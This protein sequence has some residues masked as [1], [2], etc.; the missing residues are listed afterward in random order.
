LHLTRASEVN[1][2]THISPPSPEVTGVF[3]RVPSLRFSR[4]PWYS[5]PDH[6]SRFRVRAALY[7]ARRFSWQHRIAHFALRLGI[8][9]Q[10]ME[11]GFAYVPSYILT[12]GQPSPGLNYLPA[13]LPCLTTTTL[14]RALGQHGKPCQRRTLS[15]IDSSWAIQNGYWNINQLSIDYGCRPRLRTR[16][17]LGGLA[18]PRNPWSFGG[19][20]SHPSFATHV[21]I[22]T[23]VTSTARFLCRFASYTTLSYPSTLLDLA[24]EILCE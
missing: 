15:F 17:T 3:C 10:T 6:L 2:Y 4:T 7:L 13:S 16:L 9:S 21:Y 5:L 18:W 23:R 20:V 12:P 1:P 8:R 14:G 24:A 19:R 11:R 22:L